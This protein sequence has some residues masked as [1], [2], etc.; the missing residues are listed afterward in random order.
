MSRA[1]HHQSAFI[2]GEWGPT[3][4]G[5]SDLPAY[6]QAMNVCL[7]GLPVEEGAWTKRSGFQFIMP[8]RNR[9]LAKVLPFL[10]TAT[11][12][13]GLEFTNLCMRLFSGTS[14]VFSTT[15]PTVTASS[16][17]AQLLTVTVSSATGLVVGDDCMLWAPGTLDFAAIGPFRNRI[18]QITAIAG[19]DVTL[20]DEMGAAFGAGVTSGANVLAT[21][22]LYQIMRY[23]TPW[24]GT[25]VLQNL[26]GVQGN[27]GGVPSSVL[28]SETAVPY[29]LQITETNA[30][31]GTTAGVSFA[32]FVFK[33]GP[34][35]DPQDEQG[36]VSAYSGAITFSPNATTFS[37]NDIGR[38]VRLLTVP[39]A[40][41][42]GTTY[43]YGNTVTYQGQY[44][45]SVATG[46]YAALNVGVPPGTLATSGAIQ[47]MVWAPAPQAAVWTWG[48]IT[49]QA[50]TSC[51]LSLQTGGLNSANGTTVSSF[52][53]G[54]YT[55][56]QYPTCGIYHEGRLWLG[57]AILNRFD[58]SSSNDPHSFAPTDYYGLVTDASAISETVNSD[59]LDQLLWM[60]TDEQGILMGTATGE[61]LV[62]PLF[63]DGGM[64]PTN[65]KAR[66]ITKYG[67]AFVE[68]QKTG[69]ALILV[70][71]YGQ[72]LIEYLADNFSGRFS[73]KHLNEFAKHITAAGVTE[74][75]FQE[76]KAP[77]FWVRM[78][79][80]S[81]A[82]CT[83]RRV[84]RFITD[85]PVFQAWHRHVIAG[86]YAGAVVRPV[87][88]MIV[89]P[90]DDGLSAVLYVA[91]TDAALANGA[92]EVMRP[93]YEDV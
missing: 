80:G 85:A 4:Q 39:A 25:S 55:V 61:W 15:H 36:T 48:I 2:G 69:M 47:I 93:L 40:W 29:E 74:T 92:I 11:A 7:N 81:L 30:T 46:T 31:R 72:R 82:G 42:S 19:S 41:A 86:S 27:P 3:S 84:S 49:A 73:G 54:A 32:A 1:A 6:K 22:V 18:M 59:D 34:Y 45:Q 16:L 83:Y 38:H 67:C 63:G 43:A 17:A 75:A 65:I 24:T 10:S 57:G 58:A 68:P 20:G 70:Q 35:L 5:R 71:R 9:A 50:T 12:N 56:G 14:P 88:S 91:T 51:T 77:V 37:A 87:S 62:K 23:D 33:D 13:Y 89:L 60:S 66:K 79:D 64:T 53:L 76:E 44:W 8:T 90:N 78:T 26:R 52:R 28:L 21:C